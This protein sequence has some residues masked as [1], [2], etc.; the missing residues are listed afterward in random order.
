VRYRT[1]S[2]S[3]R[4][5]AQLLDEPFMLIEVTAELRPLSPRYRSR[6]CIDSAVR[7]TDCKFIFDWYS[8]SQKVS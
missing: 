3:D 6:F 1:G 7:F 2:G 5:K 8:W 4:D